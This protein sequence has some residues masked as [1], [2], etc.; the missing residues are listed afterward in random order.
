MCVTCVKVVVVSSAATAEA[1]V[2]GMK[3]SPADA[4]DGTPSTK[5]KGAEEGTSPE[6]ILTGYL[7]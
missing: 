6:G 2:S 1:S 5:R 7:V 4:D 3:R